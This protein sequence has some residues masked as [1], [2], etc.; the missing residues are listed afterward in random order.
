[1]ATVTGGRIE[2]PEEKMPI[3]EYRCLGCG[4][5]FEVLHLSAEE[6]HPPE[7]K[8]CHSVN[9]RKLISRVRVVRSEESRLESL[10]DP[11]MMGGLDEKDPRSLAKWMKRMGKEMGEEVSDEEIEQ[12]I[13][14][15]AGGT[16]AEESVE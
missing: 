6:V 8:Y 10:M 15:A 2:N 14:D 11:S 3:Y 7:C 4:K 16:D 9:V 5:K 13:E 1:L 12:V